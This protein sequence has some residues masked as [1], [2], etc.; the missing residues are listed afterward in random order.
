MPAPGGYGL[1]GLQAKRVVGPDAGEMHLH[2][3]AVQINTVALALRGVSHPGD[4][5]SGRRA[6]RVNP[7]GNGKAVFDIEIPHGA[8]VEVRL[9][10]ED[11]GIADAS[12]LESDLAAGLRIARPIQRERQPQV[13]RGRPIDGLACFRPPLRI[14]P[15]QEIF[16]VPHLPIDVRQRSLLLPCGC[17]KQR[18]RVPILHGAA[19][20]GH[21]IEVRKYLVELFLGKR[22]VLMVVAARAAERHAHEHRGGCLDAVHY[23]L[24][25]ILLGNDSVFGIGSMVAIEA[26]S[27]LL[28]ER[29]AGQH[30]AGDLLQCE[31]IEGLIAIERLDD[32]IAPAP[33]EA[34]GIIL[35]AVGV[36]VAS[37]VEPTL[38]HALAVAR[39]S[40]EP[41]HSLRVC[42]G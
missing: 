34:L 33:H 2:L 6:I 19:Q 23:V 12:G 38:G 37:G 1:V 8:R 24:D 30:V 4:H 27:D 22:I 14:L 40:Q 18:R 5:R 17:G 20:L 15:L 9:S 25:R 35:I 21:I 13:R 32:P 10:I 41:V 42:I 3:A 7:G 36:G 11:R 16:D 26:G 39:R 28:I 29:G 31:L